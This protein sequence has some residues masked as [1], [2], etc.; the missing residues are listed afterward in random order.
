MKKNSSRKKISIVKRISI[1]NIGIFIIACLLSILATLELNVEYHIDRDAQMMR[2]YISNTLNSVDNTL[3]DMGRVSLIAFSDQTVQDILKGT[4]Y[5]F[6]EKMENDEYLTKLYSSMISIRDDVKGIYIFNKDDMVFY[7]DVANPFLGFEWDVTP[8]FQKVKVNSDLTTN[9]SGCHMYMD[10]LPEGFKYVQ[11]YTKNIFQENNIYLVRPIRSFSPYEVIGYIALRTPIFTLQKICSSYLES[12][13]SYIVA[14]ENSNIAC[15]SN[16]TIISGNLS[17]V[18]PELLN[19]MDGS[20]GSFSL[21][22]KGEKYLC[23]YQRS[24]YS[25]MLLITLKTYESIYDELTPLV[26][27]CIIITIVSALVV[28]FSVGALTR[29][30]LKRLTDFSVDIKNFQPDDLTRH[31]E[32]GYMDEVGVLKD[33]FNKMIRRLNDLVISEYQAKDELQKAEISEQKMAMLYL[34][35]QINPH[36]LYNTLDM[37]RLK[38]AINKDMEVSQMLMKLVSFYRLSTKVHDSMVAVR[39][40]VEMLDAYMSLMCYRYSDIVYHS[41]IMPEALDMEIP[42]FI[43]QPL[44]ENSLMH[45]LKDRRYQGTVTLRIW[46]NEQDKKEL[47]IWLIDDGIGI[48]D[49]KIAELNAYND[50]DNEALYRVQTQSQGDRTHLGVINVIS[51]LKLYYKENVEVVYMRN[52]TGGTTVKIKIRTASEET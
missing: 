36:F 13:V 38:A 23:A 4:D 31:Y 49:D 5:S 52:E 46:V 29:K 17:D 18:Y 25:N 14:D 20:K 47:D 32:V 28:L 26:V 12:N 2:V 27:T 8:F 42:N 37:I 51:R 6:N 19:H 10:T 43:L 35:Q 41:D 40:E 45:G 16:E 11:T 7:S 48:P 33:S 50:K 44:L 39:K 34:K 9:I 15:S 30:N 21:K 1:T 22:L 24:S 3:K